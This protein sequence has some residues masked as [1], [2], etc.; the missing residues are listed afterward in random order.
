MGT[1]G[2][3]PPILSGYHKYTHSHIFAHTHSHL[4]ASNL[5]QSPYWHVVGRWKE[6][7]EARDMDTGR[8]YTET[9]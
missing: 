9:Q 6:T 4:G 3:T 1:N 2:R 7:G 5:G 8:V